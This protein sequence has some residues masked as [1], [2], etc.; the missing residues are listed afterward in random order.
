MGDLRMQSGV[1]ADFEDDLKAFA[2]LRSD[3]DKTDERA[4]LK[5]RC[6]CALAEHDF[7]PGIYATTKMAM[8]AT[9]DVDILSHLEPG[10][11]TLD[12]DGLKSLS[13][14]EFAE[15]V[16]NGLRIDVAGTGRACEDVEHI[17]ERYAE[18]PTEAMR[19]TI[20]KWYGFEY[21][22][23][24]AWW[25]SKTKGFRSPQVRDLAC[26]MISGAVRSTN[27][28]LAPN[29][30][31]DLVRRA[32]TMN[33]QC[34][35]ILLI[36]GLRLEYGSEEFAKHSTLSRL[37]VRRILE[38]NHTKIEFFARHPSLDAVLT[39]EGIAGLNE[40]LGDKRRIS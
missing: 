22:I 13:D 21:P 6:L 18:T 26:T 8:S 34:L 17:F 4:V 40:Y 2:Q 38:S 7:L 19:A 25:L 39:P 16:E 36:A 1:I 9:I 23:T 24:T 12:T 32:S 3:P 37:S 31:R 33:G 15:V 10:Q 30:V 29:I 11:F 28:T 5:E 20:L 35:P 14:A 27:E